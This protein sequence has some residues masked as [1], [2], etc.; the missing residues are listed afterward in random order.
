[1]LRC[2]NATDKFINVDIDDIEKLIKTNKKTCV[3]HEKIL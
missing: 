2:E 1:M 3:Y